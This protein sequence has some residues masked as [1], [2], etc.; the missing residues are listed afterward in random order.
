MDRTEYDRAITTFPATVVGFFAMA[1][2]V[3]AAITE[4]RSLGVTATDTRVLNVGGTNPAAA[5]IPIAPILNP[6]QRL[7]AAI[8]GAGGR[9]QPAS[10]TPVA[11]AAA[12]AE[13]VII[14]HPKELTPETVAGLLQRHGARQVDIR[15]KLHAATQSPDAS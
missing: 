9:S 8:T 1:D 6:L 13:T 3:D 11:P 14:V 4:L 15:D 7:I 10:N 12:D 5:L 2:S